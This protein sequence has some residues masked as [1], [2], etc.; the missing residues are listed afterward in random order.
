[1]RGIQ[2]PAYPFLTHRHSN[3]FIYV[4]GSAGENL[5]YRVHSKAE[6]HRKQ[7]DYERAD[8]KTGV[9]VD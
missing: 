9:R 2:S 4:V 6:S 5:H 8:F 3:Q 7:L 1:M